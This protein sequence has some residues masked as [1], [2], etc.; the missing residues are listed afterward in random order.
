[1]RF[2]VGDKVRV[3][4]W[5]DLRKHYPDSFD[6]NWISIR[7]GFTS[8]MKTYCGEI[9]TIATVDYGGNYYTIEETGWHWGDE[10]F[11]ER[12]IEEERR[13]LRA[14]TLSEVSIY[15]CFSIS[16][17]NMYKIH[18][19]ED[20]WLCLLEK[21]VF[22]CSYGESQ[23]YAKSDI[24][25]RLTSETLPELEAKIGAENLLEFMLDLTHFDNKNKYLSI[26]TKIGIPTFKHY[27][28]MNMKNI[29]MILRRNASMLATGYSENEILHCSGMGVSCSGVHSERAIM[30]IICL[31]DNIEVLYGG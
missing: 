9:V 16:G 3:R 21:P 12:P 30:P 13:D 28:A 18:K 26:R 17:I 10:M 1:M 22:S 8:K 24:H 23:N 27:D 15:R 11:E 7:L 4:T 31:P 19:C 6:R 5:E 14:T 20:G 25:R 29:G 2:N